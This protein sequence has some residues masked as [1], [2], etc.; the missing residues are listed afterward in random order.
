M[1]SEEAT[2]NLIDNSTAQYHNIIKWL[3]EKGW[4][5]IWGP[6]MPMSSNQGNVGRKSKD[7]NGYPSLDTTYRY[8]KGQRFDPYGPYLEGSLQE[9]GDLDRAA[10]GRSMVMT[11]SNSQVSNVPRKPAT[12]ASR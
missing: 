1:G 5:Y 12:K 11:A 7:P 2:Q 10:A 4:V 6:G 9:N 8:C 3:H